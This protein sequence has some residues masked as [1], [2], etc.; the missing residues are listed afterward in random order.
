MRKVLVALILIMAKFSLSAGESDYFAYE[1]FSDISF[2]WSGEWI[3]GDQSK[4]F[5]VVDVD[6]PLEY[7]HPSGI[8]IQGGPSCLMASKSN[9]GSQSKYMYRKIEG[10]DETFYVSFLVRMSAEMAD[11]WNYIALGKK[12]DSDDSG[13][14]LGTINKKR[15]MGAAFC[16]DGSKNKY[17][18]SFGATSPVANETY[19]V[20]GKWTCDA[21][22]VVTSITMWLNPTSADSEVA[23]YTQTTSYSPEDVMTSIDLQAYFGAEAFFDEI[24]LGRTWA[25][26]VSNIIIEDATE[27]KYSGGSGTEDD[28]YQLATSEDL[29]Q[30][31]NT[32]EDWDKHFVQ[33]ANIIFD[34]AG[35]VDWNGDGTID[36]ADNVGF[37]PIGNANIHFTGS[38]DGQG[39]RIKNLFIDN[40]L[41]YTGLFGMLSHAELRNIALYNVDIASYYYVGALAGFVHEDVLIENCFSKGSVQGLSYVGGLIAY[42][43]YDTQVSSSFSSAD[44]SGQYYVGGFA[45]MTAYGSVE[46]SDAFASGK[47]DAY[48]YSGG[49]LGA[50]QY[51]LIENV[52]AT[53]QVEATYY[54]GGVVGFSQTAL[55]NSF[56]D[57]EASEVKLTAGGHAVQGKSTAEM[58][59]S[60]TFSDWDFV[61]LWSI[62]ADVNGGY[63][64]LN[65]LANAF[66]PL[67][68]EFVGEGVW[69]DESNWTN[70]VP[71]EDETTLVLISGDCVIDVEQ[72]EVGALNISSSASLKVAENVSF[73]VETEIVLEADET[74][75]AELYTSSSIPDTVIRQKYFKG[76]EWNF[77]CVPMEMKAKDLFPDMKLAE[78][79]MDPLAEYWLVEYSAEKRDTSGSGMHDVSDEDYLLEPGR[80]YMVWVDEGVIG[81]Y[82]VLVANSES[83][84]ETKYTNKGNLISEAGW[85]LVGNP[86]SHTMTY[87]DVFDCPH[88]QKY[89]TGAVYVW[90]GVSYKTWV[91]DS[92]DEEAAT[93]APMEAFFVK[94]TSSDEESKYF[95]MAA[96]DC[97]CTLTS[98][99]S[100]AVSPQDEAINGLTISLNEKGNADCDKTYIQL[101]ASASGGFDEALDAYKFESYNDNRDLIYST[102]NAKN[103]A[104]NTLPLDSADVEIPLS[105]SLSMVQQSVNLSFDIP[106][107]EAN[108]FYLIDKYQEDTVLINDGDFYAFDIDESLVIE[109]RFAVL[110]Q[111]TPTL[112]TSSSEGTFPTEE[113]LQ[114]QSSP[115][116]LSISSYTDESLQLM[117]VDMSGRILKTITMA[118]QG[119]CELR[120][121]PGG[122]ILKAEGASYQGQEKFV[123]R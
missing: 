106:S 75:V 68:T 51:A 15:K 77:I 3:A 5:Y 16:N 27:N 28:P 93:I 53:G 40:T 91:G 101:N 38:F 112:V 32:S 120:L 47:V 121:S 65:D 54:A 36:N 46:V 107:D 60:T 2:G 35:E 30:F 50:N 42:I 56:W 7:E 67:V 71:D 62:D 19:F 34:E 33:T 80:G 87:D 6:D 26:V 82:K 13:V 92:G 10:L 24:R 12:A 74:G 22:G 123:V 72:V 39:Y 11:K 105:I 98:S 55:V 100:V 59:E 64:Y 109:D 95:C 1:N 25:S 20:V 79:I 122:Y 83:M 78:S 58:Q 118:P 70:D 111:H 45:G 4:T 99:K 89:F 14:A 63:P 52:Y 104:I 23:E 97:S 21:S 29:I 73:S 69:S 116:G 86:F 49:F 115:Q 103:F 66:E 102:L 114:L 81:E 31:S 41:A 17:I 96:G 110:A 113:V 90:D 117:V 44:V 108:A 48:A 84:V 85:N 18:N 43:L 37:S 9:Y 61:E 88:N 57:V 94:R 76:G 119:Q 8:V